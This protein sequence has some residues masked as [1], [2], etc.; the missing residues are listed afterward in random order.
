[1]LM[2]YNHKVKEED[3]EEVAADIGEEGMTSNV[4]VVHPPIDGC[5]KPVNL[6]SINVCMCR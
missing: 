5:R 3:E 2:S 4:A 6:K 1:M